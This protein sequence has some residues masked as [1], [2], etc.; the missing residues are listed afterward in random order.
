M[1]QEVCS[2]LREPFM[3]YI[4]VSDLYWLSGRKVS[5]KFTLD[6]GIYGLLNTLINLKESMTP[7]NSHLKKSKVKCQ[8]G[9]RNKLTTQG[10][11]NP[12]FYYKE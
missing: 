1:S 5:G 8:I 6:I 4:L 9:H 11:E 12:L 3:E 10:L 7:T 2:I